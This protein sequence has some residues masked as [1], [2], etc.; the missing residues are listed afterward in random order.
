VSN[1]AAT[2]LIRHGPRGFRQGRLVELATLG[3]VPP[4]ACLGLLSH[5]LDRSTGAK[6]KSTRPNVGTVKLTLVGKSSGDFQVE[7]HPRLKRVRSSLG[8][9]RLLQILLRENNYN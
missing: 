7:T 4:L 2:Y 6:L 8:I 1:I 3:L 9:Y 5:S